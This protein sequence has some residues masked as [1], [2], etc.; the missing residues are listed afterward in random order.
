MGISKK[1]V[2][3]YISFKLKLAGITHS[4]IAKSFNLSN[5]IIT[6]VLNGCKHSERAEKA[7]AQTLGYDNFGTLERE[8]R[9]ILK[10]LGK[11][12]KITKNSIEIDII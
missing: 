1:Q 10:A 11:D 3:K 8:A 7:I 2:G 6:H 4:D 12:I 5:A 9:E